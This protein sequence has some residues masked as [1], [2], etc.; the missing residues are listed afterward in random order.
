MK[1]YLF[2][3]TILCL[4]KKSVHLNN[5]L[6]MNLEKATI[7][8]DKILKD[9]RKEVVP[10]YNNKPVTVKTNLRINDM[11]PLENIPKH[12]SLHFTLRMTWEDKRLAFDENTPD[13]YAAFDEKVSN[14]IWIP[15]IYFPL[16][17][18]GVF[19]DTIAPNVFVLIYGNGTIKYSQRL[20]VLS[21]CPMTYQ[22]Y[23]FDIQECLFLI[24]TFQQSKSYVILEWMIVPIEKAGED[25]FLR[26]Y[27][28]VHISPNVTERIGDYNMSFNTLQ[29][30]FTLHRD[31]SPHFLRD[32]F[33]CILTVGLSWV[34][35]FVDYKVTPA[36]VTFGITTILTI[37]TMSNSIR[38]TAPS[39]NTIRSL[40]YYMMICMLFV[41]GALVE[42][43]IVGITDPKMSPPWL[44]Q[45]RQLEKNSKHHLL[46][47]GR[48]GIALGPFLFFTDHT[49]FI[50][51]CSKV[52]FPSMFLFLNAVYF[53]YHIIHP[54]TV[55]F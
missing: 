18:K 16:G 42:F 8:L 55:T 17:K 40:D 1:N 52:A 44:K 11:V 54:Q 21:F 41:F 36:R 37:V 35:F 43:A 33:P 29:V 14:Q 9:Y 47:S 28:H 10:I 27:T 48:K 20:S 4:L 2:L 13:L 24:E 7:I 31:F 6:A 39:A 3:L 38:S 25:L 45:K 26:D 15:N 53:V 30:K 22:Y 19:H 12:F 51:D 49:H 5:K 23:P 46:S 34:S 50:D 32:Y